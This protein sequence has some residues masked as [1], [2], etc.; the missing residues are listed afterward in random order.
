MTNPSTGYEYLNEIQPAAVKK[1]VIVVGGGPA[2]ILAAEGAALVGHDVTLYEKENQLGGAFRTAPVPPEKGQLSNLLSWHI[3][4]IQK[5]GVTIKTGSLF[6]AGDYQTLQPDKLILATG[7]NPLKPPISGIGS[8]NVMQAQ[9]VLAGKVRAKQHVV[10]AGGGLVGAETAAFLAEYHHQVTIV[11][12]RPA[13]APDEELT[14]RILLMESLEKANVQMYTDSR[15]EAITETGVVIT[16]NGQTETIPC[17][18][19]VLALGVRAERSLYEQLKDYDNVAIIGDTAAPANAI[20]ATR[21]GFV[22]G[23]HA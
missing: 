14:R 19:V 15:I 5:L 1:K 6:T 7:T 9:D 10:I 16:R 3:A 11:E 23:I 2:G 20:T 18:S 13:I 21:Q 8:R 22:A 17:D 12:M 4:E